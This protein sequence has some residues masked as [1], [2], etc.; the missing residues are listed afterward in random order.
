MDRIQFNPK[1][2]GCPKSDHAKTLV[3][4]W[5]LQCFQGVGGSWGGGVHTYVYIYIYPCVCVYIYTRNFPPTHAW[6]S[7][8]EGLGF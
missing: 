1:F 8:L 3:F 2:G 4:Y 6:G 5:Y 7:S